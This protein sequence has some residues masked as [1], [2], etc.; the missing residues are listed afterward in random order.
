M[1]ILEGKYKKNSLASMM[2]S[3]VLV[4]GANLVTVALGIIR[5]KLIAVMFGA[6]GV[7]LWG[8]YSNLL[9]TLATGAGLGLSTSAVQKIASSKEDQEALRT[10]IFTLSTTIL[11]QGVICTGLAIAF[12]APISAALTLSTDNSYSISI[13][14]IAALFS[15]LSLAR[16]SVLQGQRQVKLLSQATVVG[17]ILGTA[18]GAL[19][20]YSKIENGIVL[21][22]LVQPVSSYLS[23]LYYTKKAKLH[24]NDKIRPL[25][26]F[27]AWLALAAVGV[28]LMLGVL[29]QTSSI[30]AVRT[31]ITQHLGVVE[32]GLFAASWTIA[33]HYVGF[34][35]NSMAVDYLPRLSG[36]ISSKVE[37]NILVNRQIQLGLL[38]ATPI[39]LAMIVYAPTIV[40]IFYSQEFSSISPIIRWQMVGNF[41]KLASWPLAF[42]LIAG[43]LPVQFLLVEVIWNVLFLTIVWIGIGELGLLVTGYSFA[44]CYIVY[45]VILWFYL[46]MTFSL[47]LYRRT[48][49][50]LVAALVSALAILALIYIQSSLLHLLGAIICFLWTICSIYA[51]TRKD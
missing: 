9:N 28:P 17:A 15:M 48:L 18:L 22:I 27:S 43:K 13:V 38:V 44:F 40:S 49:W 10:T 51:L 5:L 45:F 32:V 25:R 14:A 7:G 37:Q 31:V 36:C 50:L 41:F 29:V 46:Q 8:I 33:M 35:F 12:S 24:H 16:M 2:R 39:L 3:L 47:T 26:I 11:I 6:A 19:I 20:L 1:K 34:L 30:L 4:G 23:A 42:M 21:F